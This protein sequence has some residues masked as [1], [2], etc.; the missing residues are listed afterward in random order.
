MRIRHLGIAVW[1]YVSFLILFSLLLMGVCKWYLIPAM[2]DFNHADRLQKR[3][4]GLHALLIMMVVLLILALGLLLTYRLG[5]YFSRRPAS[6]R[7]ATK[8]VDA[9]SESAKRMQTPPKE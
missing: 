1:P 7:T 2:D 4:L 9:W 6:Q 8:Y 5:R 3:L